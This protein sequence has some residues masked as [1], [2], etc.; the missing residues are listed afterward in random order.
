MKKYLLFSLLV[1]SF[2]NLICTEN[3]KESELTLAQQ[4]EKFKKENPVSLYIL[5]L[6]LKYQ[7]TQPGYV[8]LHD[9]G[10][11]LLNSESSYYVLKTSFTIDQYATLRAEEEEIVKFN[12]RKKIMEELPKHQYVT[13]EYVYFSLDEFTKCQYGGY[14]FLHPKKQ[15]WP[16]EHF[17]CKTFIKKD[18]FKELE[19]K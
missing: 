10:I 19:N 1:S 5:E 16:Q 11:E 14:K 17:L 12:L 4:V 15:L 2:N 9:M 13:K 18:I 7:Q 6:F 3:S 8:Q